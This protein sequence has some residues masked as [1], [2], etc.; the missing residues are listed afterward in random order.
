MEINQQPAGPIEPDESTGS[1]PGPIINSSQQA[2]ALGYYHE[3]TIHHHRTS[4]D[5]DQQQVA[6]GEAGPRPGAA[7][8]R[9]R[10]P[11]IVYAT[12][13][14]PSGRVQRV[15]GREKRRPG[16]LEAAAAARGPD[17]PRRNSRRTGGVPAGR[18]STTET[19]LNST[20]SSRCTCGSSRSSSC[21]LVS[22]GLRRHRRRGSGT[23]VRCWISSSDY[24]F[25]LSTER[26]YK[27]PAKPLL[28]STIFPPEIFIQ[29]SIVFF[30]LSLY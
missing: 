22:S 17:P 10:R 19:Y 25:N 24:R 16:T 8:T 23:A 7:E 15:S 1:Q 5:M 18:R 11:R 4:G 21:C 2:K 29:S 3:F 28:V 27:Q 20:S 12:S 6:A 9:G 26:I 14:P 13:T 30:Q